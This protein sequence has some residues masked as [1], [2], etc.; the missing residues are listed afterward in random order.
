MNKAVPVAAMPTRID[1]LVALTKTADAASRRIHRHVR[2]P[3]RV[4]FQA[5]EIVSDDDVPPN[6]LTTEE[7]NELWYHPVDLVGFKN[8]AR[9]ISRRMRHDTNNSA[10]H[11]RG[12]EQRISME[13]QKNKYLSIRA[14]LKAQELNHSPRELARIASKC[15]AWAKEIALLT[16]HKDYY[17]AYKPELEHLVPTT[18]KVPQPLMASMTTTQVRKRPAQVIVI[19]DEEEEQV[20]PRRI[21]PR[22]SMQHSSPRRV[23]FI[24]AR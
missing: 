21:R 5:T 9:E 15:S 6:T 4:S 8:E 11:T 20:N 18:P 24:T 13:R 23:G 19:D 14:I 12:L 17:A 2:A 3:R 7:R 22:L 16:G 1:S 10:E